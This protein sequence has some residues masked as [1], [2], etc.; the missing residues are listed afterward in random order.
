MAD[1]TLYT[2]TYCPY[3]KQAKALLSRKGLEY[4]DS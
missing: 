2:K 1:I 3:F 4:E